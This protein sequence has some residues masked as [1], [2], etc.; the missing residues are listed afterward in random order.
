[1]WM[2]FQEHRYYLL[3]QEISDSPDMA[4]F[5]TDGSWTFSLQPDLYTS[6]R[7]SIEQLQEILKDSSVMIGP[8]RFPSDSLEVRHLNDGIFL[9]CTSN[10]LLG[11]NKSG[12]L[13]YRYGYP[14]NY[15]EFKDPVDSANLP[16]G[17]WMEFLRNL[18]LVAKLFWFMANLAHHLDMEENISY[19]LSAQGIRG[20]QLVSTNFEIQF[21]FLRDEPS[22]APDYSIEK[23]L[24]VA[25][26]RSGWEEE[27]IEALFRF[28][29]LFKEGRISKE[30]LTTYLTKLKRQ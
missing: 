7:W 22:K 10:S 4:A 5:F 15:R 20:R 24:P 3:Q 23:S 17:K 12:L 2:Q 29:C 13:I 9:K 28:F 16:P 6:D 30:T 19:Q 11:F 1:M 8:S 27:C 25:E 14:E 18:Y 26:L 21:T